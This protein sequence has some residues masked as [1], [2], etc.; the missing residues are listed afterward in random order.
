M[1][2]QEDGGSIVN[3]ASVS[4][5]R[6]SPG[7]AAYG[8]AKAGLLNLTTV[9]GHRVGAEGP[10]QRA[11][12]RTGGHRG[13]R[14][15]LRRGRR[16]WPRWR[17]PCPLGRFGTPD[18]M[19]GICLFL[20]SPLAAYVT[21]A[22]LVAHGGGERPAFLD[23]GR[24]RRAAAPD[25]RPVRPGDRPGPAA[26]A[27]LKFGPTRD[28]GWRRGPVMV[29]PTPTGGGRSGPGVARVM[30]TYPE[31]TF[32]LQGTPVPGVPAG[33]RRLDGPAARHGGA[34]AVAAPDPWTDLA[35]PADSGGGGQRRH[36]GR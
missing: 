15:P 3:I 13:R 22:N 17:P 27:P 14:R 34:R 16:A 6:P 7:T 32:T 31:P 33:R 2:D 5:L 1:Q 12:R 8:A 4:G 29:E 23:G 11:E 20:A 26:P 19:A 25:A 24:G 10:G 9:A 36:R 18:D 28:D 21:G 30:L 35:R